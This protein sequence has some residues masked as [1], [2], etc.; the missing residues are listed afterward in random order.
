MSSV[1]PLLN[2]CFCW[3]CCCCLLVYPLDLLSRYRH[4]YCRSNPRKMVKVSTSSIWVFLRELH[5]SAIRVSYGTLVDKFC[6][7]GVC[8]RVRR[9]DHFSQP[10]SAFRTTYRPLQWPC[11]IWLHLG[12][13]GDSMPIRLTAHLHIHRCTTISTQVWAEKEMRNLRRLHA[14]GVCA[15]IPPLCHYI[16][17][18][19]LGQIIRLPLRR[20]TCRD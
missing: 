9:Q 18:S 10:E 6:R 1:Q 16:S 11:R 3:S 5:R 4:G 13:A 8:P 7:V 17:H 2:R 15:M 20:H 12:G 19:I 14:A